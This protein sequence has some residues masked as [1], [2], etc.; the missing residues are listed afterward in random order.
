MPLRS[1]D[2]CECRVE[3]IAQTTDGVISISL[4]MASFI[5]GMSIKD[6]SDESRVIL[7]ENLQ[8]NYFISR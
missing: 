3:M 4:N 5:R 6:T 1:D 7:E 2:L 8:N